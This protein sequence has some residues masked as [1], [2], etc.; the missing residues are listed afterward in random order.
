MKTTKSMTRKVT[1]MVTCASLMLL[2]VG[3]W[4]AFAAGASL[5]E[6]EAVWGKAVAVHKM[7]NGAEKRFYKMQNTQDVGFRYFTYKDGRVIDDGL[8][9]SAPIAAKAEKTGL[10]SSALSQ[11]YYQNHPTSAQALDQAWGKAAAV[12]TVDGGM[13]ERYYKVQNTQD[14]G[15]RYF[16]IKDGKVVASGLARVTGE[17]EKAAELKGVPVGFVKSA[18][19]ESVAEVES[20]WGKP[21]KVKKLANGNEERYYKIDN[22]MNFGSKMFLFKDGKAI[23]SAVAN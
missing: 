4:T 2:T 15:F 17:K 13:E 1:V 10:P 23:A 9:G 11:S 6:N 8:I 21:L 12:R 22:T 20:V 18:G 19:V 5:Q 16:Q 14:L 7:D 3:A